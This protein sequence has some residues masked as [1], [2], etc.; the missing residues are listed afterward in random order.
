MHMYANAI[1]MLYYKIYIR[2]KLLFSA[3]AYN[4]S[5][6]HLY[7]LDSFQ[8]RCAKWISGNY[9]AHYVQNLK[10]LK[11]LSI[12]YHHDYS[13]IVFL[14]K[15]HHKIIDVKNPNIFN[16]QNSNSRTK[17]I[18]SSPLIQSERSRHSFWYRSTKL[19]NALCVTYFNNDNFTSFKSQLIQQ[20][21]V[22]CYQNYSSNSCTWRALCFCYV[23]RNNKL[24]NS[25]V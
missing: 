25:N 13:T 2:P 15:C 4:I 18:F 3:E 5:S 19:A 9:V 1:C 12:G 20:L 22:N 8:R 11:L 21:S 23:C 16:L 17:S 6:T 14:Y 24:I 10:T 7:H